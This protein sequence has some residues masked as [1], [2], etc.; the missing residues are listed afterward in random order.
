[1]LVRFRRDDLSACEPVVESDPT[2]LIGVHPC[3]VHGIDILDEV[4]ADSP[5]DANYLARRAATWILALECQS[6]CSPHNLCVDKATNRVEW[7]YDVL[8]VDLG[9]RYFI[10][11]RTAAGES[12]VHEQAC[13]RPAT[14]ADREALG[15]AREMQN[16][17]FRPRLSGSVK[18]LPG[19]LKDAYGSILWDAAGRRCL[20]C[21]TCTMVCPTSSCF[22]VVD[23]VAF[24]LKAGHRCRVWDRFQSRIFAQVASGE[25][26]RGNAWQRQRHR[27]FKKEV[28]QY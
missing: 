14:P 15:R 28:Y 4:F 22:D 2:I 27:V 9:D 12:M 7:G 17:S 21:E 10:F 24:D 20:S 3:D 26:F 23:E 18:R 11:A 13:L 6:P 25:N 8:M 5:Y 19:S 1:M 16:A